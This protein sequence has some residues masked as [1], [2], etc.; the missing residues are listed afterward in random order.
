MEPGAFWETSRRSSF[1]L[2]S[3]LPS[4]A[5]MT[6]PRL[7][8]ALSAGS[9]SMTLS[10]S[11]PLVP[12]NAEGLGHVGGEWRDVDADEAAAHLAGLR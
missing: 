11:T 1:G 4:S 9:P 3:G 7:M 2:S 12:F 5:V 8:P 6:S 10:T